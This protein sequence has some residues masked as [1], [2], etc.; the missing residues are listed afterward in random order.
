M[1]PTSLQCAS[2]TNYTR[3]D[4]YL[5][6]LETRNLVEVRRDSRGCRWIT[7]TPP[8]KRVAVILAEGVAILRGGE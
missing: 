1:R 4:R 3:F 6:L 5:R 7:L 2:E 8:G